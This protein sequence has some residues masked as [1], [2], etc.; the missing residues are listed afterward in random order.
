MKMNL[1]YYLFWI[2]FTFPLDLIC[3]SK[4]SDSIN[5]KK[6]L[7]IAYELQFTNPDTSLIVNKQALDLSIKIKWSKGEAQSLHERG[8]YYVEISEYKNA[9]KCYQDAL[10]I[11]RQLT[12]SKNNKLLMVGKMGI[13][14]STANLGTVYTD[15][16]EYG[17]ALTCEFYALKQYEKLNQNP[18]ITLAAI[19]K[20]YGLQKNYAL[21]REYY[22]K[23]LKLSRVVGD[24]RTEGADLICLGIMCS[25]EKQY[26]SAM[27]YYNQALIIAKE[28]NAKSNLSTCLMNI[29]AIY[30]HLEKYDSA[31]INYNTALLIQEELGD[32]TNIGQIQ[33]NIGNV[34]KEMGKY[35]EA[36]QWHLKSLVALNKVNSP[37][38]IKNA[39][40][41][42]SILYEN[43]G[44]FKESLI[45]Y[46]IFIAARDSI[47]NDENTKAQARTE[48]QYEF[49]K[50]QT[51]D[52]IKTAEHTKQEKFKHETEIA[53]QKMYTYGGIG[54]FGL[55]LVV[56]FVSFRAFRNKQK[57]NL[58]IARQKELVEEKQKE[59]LDSI[60]Y[61]K[62]IQ[63][64]LLPSEKYIRKSLNK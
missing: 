14:K 41:D 45:H 12:K 18:Y 55:M 7:D 38:N 10:K 6:L 17:K 3:Q 26:P 57:A 22:L 13:A 24:K 52:S 32:I 30:V 44:K 4:L 33:G 36:I 63:L 20:I 49:D 29:G 40:R 31:M 19:G 48:M 60:R 2:L 9:E 58:V 1:E 47:T 23:S 16:A 46:K 43:I 61:A 27:N 11:W 21:S 53:Q 54:G 15:I 64:A 50:Q 39:E 34:F 42:L 35:N 59:I 37:E 62:R 28:V 51:A 25:K 5:V 56:A 8:W